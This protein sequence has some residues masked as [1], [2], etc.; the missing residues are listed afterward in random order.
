M[1]AKIISII[2]ARDAKLLWENARDSILHALEHFT[3]LSSRHGSEAHHK[4][5]IVLSVHHAAE[6]FCN[7]LLKQFDPGNPA[8]KRNG[9]DRYPSLVPAIGE[10]I[11]LK[12]QAHLTVAPGPLLRSRGSGLTFRFRPPPFRRA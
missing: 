6:A 10:L 2:T 9:K 5:W 8:F 12:N 7:M 1:A 11:Q 3:D 4:K